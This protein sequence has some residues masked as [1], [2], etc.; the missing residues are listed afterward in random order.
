MMALFKPKDPAALAAEQQKRA[1]HVA[2]KDTERAEKEQR[3][4]LRSPVG[5]ARI[6]FERGDLVFQYSIDVMNQTGHHC[7]DDWKYH[8]APDDGFT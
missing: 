5:A 6:A 7:E 4:F 2:Q 1:E 3:A 8:F